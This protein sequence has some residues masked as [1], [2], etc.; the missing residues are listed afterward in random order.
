[1]GSRSHS[2]K[3]TAQSD[4]LLDD[5]AGGGIGRAHRTP[6]H[7][8]DVHGAPEIVVRDAVRARHE[9]AVAALDDRDADVVTPREPCEDRH[10]SGVSDV[11]A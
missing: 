6:V 5:A 11:V 4:E 2:G 3:L 9:L 1:M 10:D 7:H 8:R